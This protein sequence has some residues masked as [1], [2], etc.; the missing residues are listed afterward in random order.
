MNSKEIYNHKY[1]NENDQFFY[2]EN[3]TKGSLIK[4]GT[5]LF[6]EEDYVPGNSV[7]VKRKYSDKSEDWQIL[8]NNEEFLLLKGNRFKAAERFYL[9]TSEGV[10]FL[11]NGIK[12]GLKTTSDF[13][14]EI[15]NI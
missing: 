10:L 9:R 6:D 2:D 11:I 5:E 8:V 12:K 4:Q 14:R 1:L 13:V 3:S 15:K 7:C